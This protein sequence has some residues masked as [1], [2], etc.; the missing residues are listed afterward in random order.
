MCVSAR[1]RACVCVCVRA[2]ARARVRACVCVSGYQPCH[3]LTSHC[4]ATVAECAQGCRRGHG[5]NCRLTRRFDSIALQ[6]QQS[7]LTA[8]APMPSEGRAVGAPALN[9]SVPDGCA[10]D[11]QHKVGTVA[12]QHMRAKAARVQ[13]KRPTTEQSRVGIRSIRDDNRSRMRCNV[14]EA[15]DVGVHM[16]RAQDSHRSAPE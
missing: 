11:R 16:R 7:R 8:T 13:G 15:A 6:T 12:P 3:A 10:M 14:S 2:R 4:S 9:T 1:A 5:T